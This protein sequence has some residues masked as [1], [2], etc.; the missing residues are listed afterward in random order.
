MEPHKAMLKLSSILIGGACGP[1][2]GPREGFPIEGYTS[3]IGPVLAQADFRFVNCMRTYSSRGVYS[4]HARQVGQPLEMADIFS[5]GRFDAVTMAN[6]HSYDSGPDAL[7]DT[8]ALL[9]SRGIQVTGAGRDL[10]EARKPAIVE[11]NGV[12]VGY[13][14]Y[15]SVGHPEGTA[16]HGKPG[17]MNLRVNTSYDTRGPHQPVRI[18]TEPHSDDLAML[19]EDVRALRKNADVAI[20]AFHSGVIRLPRVVSDYQVAVAHAAIDAGADVVVCHAPHIPKAIEVYRGKVIFYS[21][22]VFAMTKPFAAPSWTDEPA[23]AHGAVRNHAD[24]DPSYP[25]MPYGQAS[26]LSLLAKVQVSDKSVSNVSF[27]PMTFDERYRPQVLDQQDPRFGK[28]AAYMEW[29]SED[30]PHTFT[31]EGNEVMVSE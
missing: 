3:L 14:G 27:L 23:W 2:H 10:A 7:V 22:G 19:L 9:E 29:T 26:T 20:L 30:M 12:K 5:N 4:E 8:R 16:G 24:L 1:A 25:Y 15:T 28:I 21:L 11:R 18:R 6:N 17:V 13:L 31:I